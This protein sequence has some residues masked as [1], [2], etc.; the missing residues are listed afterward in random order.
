MDTRKLFSDNVAHT[1]QEPLGL[2]I[3]FAKGV[4]LYDEN[5]KPVLDLI[6]GIGVNILGHGH[7]SVVAA[8]K[9]QI[10]KYMHTMVYGECILAPQVELAR[11]LSEQ[12]PD[13]LDSVY[14]ANSGS[15]AVEGAIK[16]SRKL[17]RRYEIVSCR[18]AYHGSSLGANSLLSVSNFTRAYRPMVPGIRFIDYNKLE[19]LERITKKTAAVI[20]ETIQGEAG[21]INP[22]SQYLKAVGERCREVGALM[23][24][25]EIQSGFGRT[26]YL[27]AF[28]K[29]GVI[30]DILLVGK[31]MGG[32]MP[33]AAFISSKDKM[34][35][36][37]S[38]PELGH[39]TTFGGHPVNCAAALATLKFLIEENLVGTVPAKARLL[40]SFL[41]HRVIKQV[42]SSGLW[43]ALDLQS[44][45]KVK[46]VVKAG[47]REGIL[48]DWFLFNKESIR[49]APPLVITDEEIR[50]A[51]RKLQIALDDA[52]T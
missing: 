47:L 13:Q 9:K 39:L 32:G 28:E 3:E 42:R 23:V 35:E 45:D 30:P 43:F 48:I 15:E 21:L 17:T 4:Y 27:F 1:S 20:M 19:D 14:F 50:E 44:F 34:K 29:Y 33:I 8:V 10:D 41:K 40:Q 18:N 5:N 46:R 6:S 12:L 25:D 7:P 51:G 31:A 38:K 2:Q 37:A 16:L 24:L 49:I 11:M 52:I 26:G 36:L 22:G